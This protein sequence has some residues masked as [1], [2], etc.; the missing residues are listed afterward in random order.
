MRL[1]PRLV[2]HPVVLPTGPSADDFV[3]T[4]LTLH[5][6]VQEGMRKERLVAICRVLSEGEEATVRAYVAEAGYQV[7]GGAI[8]ER[9]AYREAQNRGRSARQDLC[10]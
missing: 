4:I 5:E 7:L 2:R 3:P 10:N 1:S 9:I 8:P 6:L